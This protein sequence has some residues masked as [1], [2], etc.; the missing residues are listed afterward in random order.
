M[1]TPSLVNQYELECSGNASFPRLITKIIHRQLLIRLT[2]KYGCGKD[3]SL[4]C[5][6]AIWNWNAER[7]SRSGIKN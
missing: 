4:E 3:A 6:P 2:L 7:E 5:G 1:H